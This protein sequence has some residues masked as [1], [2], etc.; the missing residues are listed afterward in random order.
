MKRSDHS[1]TFWPIGSLWSLLQRIQFYLEDLRHTS[2][3]AAGAE[4]GDPSNDKGTGNVSFSCWSESSTTSSLHKDHKLIVPVEFQ[5][6][7]GTRGIWRAACVQTLPCSLCVRNV[8]LQNRPT[9]WFCSCSASS[10]L[11]RAF[12]YF[13]SLLL[14]FL[15]LHSKNVKSPILWTMLFADST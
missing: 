1:S 9:S 5:S 12:R 4:T 3:P 11:G 7:G 15:A 13:L 10:N 6:A 2:S 8:L 14:H